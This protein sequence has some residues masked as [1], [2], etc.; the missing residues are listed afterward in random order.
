MELIKR[1]LNEN[2]KLR[3]QLAETDDER[4]RQAIISEIQNNE[5]KVHA[6]MKS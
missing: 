6:L 4:T 5:T 3:A 1:L 2:N